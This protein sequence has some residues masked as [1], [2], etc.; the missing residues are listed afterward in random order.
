MGYASKAGRARISSRNP[1]AFAVCDRCGIW[2]NHVDLKW[3]FDWAGASL[4]N[5]RMLVCTPCY[6]QPQQQL[7]A[8]VLP[9]DPVPILNP[10]TEPY[11]YDETD[12]RQTSGQNTVDPWTNIPVPGGDTRVTSF[13]GQATNDKRVTQQTGEPPYGLNQLPGTDPNAVTYRKIANVI[14]NG[15]GLI[16]LRM[17]TTNGMITGQKVIV[18]EVNGVPN[19]NGEFTIVVVNNTNIVLRNSAFAGSYIG[20]GYVINN[21]SVPLGF[22]EIPRTGPLPPYQTVDGQSQWIND[23]GEPVLW[24]NDSGEPVV[25]LPN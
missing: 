13:D 15:A 1:Q 5:K 6:D 22:D 19:A 8:I 4:I 12:Y 16:Q 21:P 9:A 11:L 2:Y 25:W 18:R 7:R 23:S 20:N 3:Q 17:S 10:R 24:I 14:N